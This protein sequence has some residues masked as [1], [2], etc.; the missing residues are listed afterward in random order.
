MKTYVKLISLLCV[1]AMLISLFAA[2][3]N[4]DDPENTDPIATTASPD[5]TQAADP[6][7]DKY[8]KDGYLKDDLPED[9]NYSG[10]TVSILYWDDVERVEFDVEE[11]ETGVDMVQ[12][13]VYERN[14]TVAD[15]LGVEFD[16][17]GTPGDNGERANFVNFA[18]N[19]YSSGVYYDIIA[20]YSR[21]ATMLCADGL[22][23]DIN[24]IEDSYINTEMPWWPASMT[25]TCSIGDSLYF[26][27]GDISTNILH[28]MYAIYYNMDL[29][30]NLQLEDPIELVDN[31]KW[32]LDKLIE[33]SKGIYQD[34]DQDG[35]V[36]IGDTYGFT[37]T[38]FHLDAFYSGSGL[39]L[40]EQTGNDS[41]PLKISDD[42]FGQN[43]VDLVDK[44]GAWFKTGDAFCK[45]RSGGF[46]Y[47][48]PFIEGRSVFVQN[49]VYMADNYY[50]NAALRSVDWEYG[51]LP[52]PLYDE[53]QDNYI[54]LLGNPITLWSVMDSAADPSMSSAVIECFASEG[55]RKTSPA[56][57]EN[58]MKYRYTPDTEGKGD[59]ARMF[60]LIRENI[61]FDLGRLFS[62][63]LNYMSEMPSE[64]AA[65]SRSWASS[66]SQYQRVLNKAVINLN[67]ALA[68]VLG[69]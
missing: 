20:T 55:Y 65:G 69:K 59:S 8:D 47:D 22:L 29:L 44:L 54:T 46:A 13:A 15:R 41:E 6:D 52:T 11:S 9:L 33:I 5:A 21:T 16:W 17:I 40:I 60:D 12:D 57:F 42:F 24:A 56:L 27:S 38:Y 37:S 68:E 63:D 4:T 45:E 30:E 1:L 67:K 50:Q 66:K 62:N 39:R 61:N 49:R 23:Q 51:I 7:A 58:N 26:V 31:K 36:S 14:L 48:T 32:T 35:S 43:A 64:A 18:Q 53:S 3:A 28:F 10:E 2:C 19:A 34:T 25:D